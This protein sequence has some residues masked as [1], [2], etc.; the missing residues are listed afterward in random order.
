LDKNNLL[1]NFFLINGFKIISKNT[2]YFYE[3]Q[4]YRWLIKH[5]ISYRKENQK[6]DQLVKERKK[7]IILIHLIF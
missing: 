4:K 5:L 1:K 6:E 3:K 2:K 7:N